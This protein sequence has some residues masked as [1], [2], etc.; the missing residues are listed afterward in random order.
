MTSIAILGSGVMGSALTFPLS[1][2]GH[3]IRLVGTH[4][5]RDIIDS[6]RATGV[7]PG[8]K[9]K[10]PESV[11]PYQVE[12]IETA[13]DG[14]EIIVSGVNSLGV[15]W[16]GQRIAALLE[17]DMLVIAIAKGM[18][19]SGNGDL[20]ILPDVLAEQVPP[21]LRSRVPWAAIGGPSIAGEV[22]ARRDTCVVFTGREQAALDRL[23]ATFRT[24]WYHVWT[25]TDLVGVEVSAA[26]KNCYAVGVGFAEGV[27]DRL[28]QADSPDRNHNYEAALFAQGAVE[29]GQMVRLLGGR[30][31][32]PS[33]L[34]G[35]GDMFVTSTG[36][37][38]VRVGRLV[39]GG[40]RFSDARA[41][42]GD[43][44]L[45]GAAAIQ[46][47]GGALPKLAARGLIGPED[48]PLMR[49]LHAVVA[50]DQPLR[51]PWSA[52]LGGEAWAGASALA[53]RETEG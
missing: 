7:H 31:E 14:V 18:A 17:P 50:Q 47:I 37:R 41:R 29:I 44:T 35:V 26:M 23:A 8:L 5:D 4:L 36:G 46:V 51:M 28:G 48:F 19:A 49:H 11:R 24:G 30:P 9:R 38:N 2:N 52:F 3:D 39:G 10:L 21:E 6:V 25:S 12:E 1:D 16:A 45:E 13:F 34:A 27:L 40:L 22:A 15:Q 33:G 43:I 32:T 42:M 20:R 53:A